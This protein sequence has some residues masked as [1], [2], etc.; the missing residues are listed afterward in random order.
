MA[1]PNFEKEI[2]ETRRRVLDYLKP[3]QRETVLHVDRLFSRGIRRVLVADEVGLGKTLVA[4]G[5]V[6]TTAALRI[7]EGDDLFKVAYVCSNASIVNQN[8]AKLSVSENLVDQVKETE[9]RLSMQHFFA[10]INER[11]AKQDGNFIQ[12]IP[13]TPE[14][15]FNVTGGQG[16][17]NERALIFATLRRH[18]AFANLQKEL[19]ELFICDATQSWPFWKQHY[20]ELVGHEAAYLSDMQKRLQKSTESPQG[21]GRASPHT[22]EQALRPRAYWAYQKRICIAQYRKPQSRPCRHG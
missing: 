4:R 11:K 12:L 3:F 10:Y 13:L 22:R 7:A 8:L 17:V 1:Y 16:T 19:E 21:V 2:D 20:E 5:V 9:S 14:T 6:A 18:E 15:S